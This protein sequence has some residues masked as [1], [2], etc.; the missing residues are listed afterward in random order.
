[1]ACAALHVQAECNHGVKLG[2][3]GTTQ[4]AGEWGAGTIYPQSLT[5]V[6]APCCEGARQQA[7]APP[8]HVAAAAA[9]APHHAAMQATHA[10]AC[11]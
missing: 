9:P 11:P 5:M 3:A 2:G 7:A 10:S 8:P 1:M 6:S 4:P